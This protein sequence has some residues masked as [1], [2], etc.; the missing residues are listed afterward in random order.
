MRSY[1]TQEQAVEVAKVFAN[2]RDVL[3]VE[4]VGSV[5]RESRGNDLDLVV[6]VGWYTYLRYM[7]PLR[8][9]LTITDEPDTVDAYSSVKVD[10][11]DFAVAA[12]DFKA[13]QK[14]WLELA[15][16]SCPLD[17]HLMPANWC[18]DADEIQG[19]F[20]F[21][22][23]EFVRNIAEDAVNLLVAPDPNTGLLEV[24]WP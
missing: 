6:V 13:A 10:R 19:L 4:V 14:G 8:K 1:V 5:A 11:L 7:L 12:L 23:T 2:A 21:A 22:D 20:N 3:G 17:I 18:K 15:T 9:R 24:Y 16:K